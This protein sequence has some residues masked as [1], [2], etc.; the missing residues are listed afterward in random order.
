MPPLHLIGRQLATSARLEQ[1]FEGI[2]SP[3]QSAPWLSTPVK[4]GAVGASYSCSANAHRPSRGLD[5]QIMACKRPLPAPRDALAMTRPAFSQQ[6][7][8]PPS[9]GEVCP[10]GDWMDG[11]VADSDEMWGPL[12]G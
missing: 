10:S 8:A 1:V 3:R 6:A 2:P 7:A 12:N 4:K 9:P 5:D 11:L